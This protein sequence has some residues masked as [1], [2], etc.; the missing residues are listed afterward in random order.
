MSRVVIGLCALLMFVITPSVNADPLV[1]TS[2]TASIS[3]T[4]R[5]SY[6]LIGTNFTST[7]SNGDEG[8]APVTGCHPC[9]GPL[10]TVQLGVFF[11]CSRLGARFS[12]PHSTTAHNP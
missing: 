4:A 12:T 8:N 6:N 5:I 11:F 2:G 1:I 3:Q 10:N 9:G 7:G